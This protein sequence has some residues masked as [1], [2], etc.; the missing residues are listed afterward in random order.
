MRYNIDVRCRTFH[1]ISAKKR[2]SDREI[3]KDKGGKG[4]KGIL[5]GHQK[6]ANRNSF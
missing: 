2:I 3:G 5:T 4:M 6:S 1:L